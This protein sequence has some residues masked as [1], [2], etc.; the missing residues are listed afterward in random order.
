MYSKLIGSNSPGLFIILVDQSQSMAD[1]YADQNKAEF[2]ALAVNR[3]IYEILE[4]CMAGEKI[5]DRC[6]IS[7]IGYGEKTEMIVGGLPTEIKNPPHGHQTYKRKIS[8][9]AG[10]LVDV[11]QSLPIWVKARSANGTPMGDA[12]DLA[13]DLIQAWTREKPENFP[14]VVF[15]IT[16]GEPNDTAAAKEGARKA[17]SFKTADGS[18]LVYNCHIGTGTPEIKLPAS[19]ASLT[20]PGAKLLFEMSSVIPPELFRLAQ[21]AG[22]TPQESSRGFCMNASPETFIKLLTFGSAMAR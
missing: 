22:L 20:E 10:G 4:S 6:H 8:D 15:N 3:T 18:V 13:V 9:G 11:E 12:F 7:V 2:A 21:N 17:A 14:P 19:D 5:K 1:P 16:D